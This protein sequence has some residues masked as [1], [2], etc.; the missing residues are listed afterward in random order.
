MTDIKNDSVLVGSTPKTTPMLSIPPP[1]TPTDTPKT[2][3]PITDSVSDSPSVLLKLEPSPLSRSIPSPRTPPPTLILSP[4]RLIR[5]KPAVRR[6][7][8]SSVS[9]HVSFLRTST[10]S[11]TFSPKQSDTP[12]APQKNQS[13][14]LTRSR[15]MSSPTINNLPQYRYSRRVKTPRNTNTNINSATTSL[16]PTRLIINNTTKPL[17]NKINTHKHTNPDHTKIINTTVT[18]DT[19]LPLWTITHF[20]DTPKGYLGAYKLHT[21]ESPH[22]PSPNITGRYQDPTRTNSPE[23]RAY[24]KYMS[25]KNK[26]I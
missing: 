23:C 19:K 9:H 14:R 11:P 4:S 17:T 25:I 3:T 10:P 8:L 5:K 15:S 18:K 13:P 22:P 26:C 6:S 21:L 20:R 24:K 7:S 1:E 16:S 12:S 2:Q